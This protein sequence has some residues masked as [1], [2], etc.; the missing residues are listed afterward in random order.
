[1]SV[2]LHA[3]LTSENMLIIA[4]HISAPF[5]LRSFG[6][7]LR[8]EFKCSSISVAVFI[9]CWRFYLVKKFSSCTNGLPTLI[10]W[11]DA[12]NGSVS[13]RVLLSPWDSKQAITA[14]YSCPLTFHIRFTLCYSLVPSPPLQLSSLAVRVALNYVK[15]AV[16]S[17]AQP[18]SHRKDIKESPWVWLREWWK[19]GL[20]FCHAARARAQA[21]IH[22]CGL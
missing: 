3:V 13:D 6:Y 7:F 18:D 2:H 12:A 5:P 22:L 11:K 1:M 10:S 8:R 14:C 16:I 19:W 17:L 9:T 15:I 4:T 21:K 20:T